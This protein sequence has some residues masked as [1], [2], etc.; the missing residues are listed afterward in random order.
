MP[1]YRLRFALLT[2]RSLVWE[3]TTRSRRLDDVIDRLSANGARLAVFHQ[4]GIGSGIMMGPLL[5]VMRRQWPHAAIDLLS[6]QPQDGDVLKSVGL[7]ERH[8]VVSAG[9][10]CETEAFDALLSA[11]RTYHGDR[12][13]HAVPANVKIGFRHQ[14][15][16]H[17]SSR[18]F[19][20]IAMTIDPRRHE[21]EQDLTLLA[22]L[23]GG[24]P[25][26]AVPRTLL[27]VTRASGVPQSRPRVFVHAGSSA[28]MSWKRWPPEKFAEV[29][30][31]LRE[32]FDAQ[33]TMV[34]GPDERECAAEIVGLL[35]HGAVDQ[36]APDSIVALFA[37][38]RDVDCAISND[39]A[40]MHLACAAGTNAVAIF[41]GTDPAFCGPWAE[42]R[43]FRVVRADLSCSPC[44]RP[45]SGALQCTNPN[46]LQCLSE[47]T[48]ALVMNAAG[49]LLGSTIAA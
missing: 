30:R 26:P 20:D 47:V 5:Q 36:F 17:T 44:Y 38:L 7:I 8:H 9:R 14:V 35:P 15:G 3:A 49:E 46:R 40:F 12:L 2:S 41:G 22:P 37:A 29:I 13:V 6:Q 21:C 45:Y 27:G 32:R 39:G 18:L 1:S 31:Q 11:S 43:H 33:V 25:M 16:W 28:G 10:D 48:P 23:L 34:S 4:G 24:Q 42:P 19:H